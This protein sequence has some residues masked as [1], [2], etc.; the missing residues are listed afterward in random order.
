[1]SDISGN[2]WDNGKRVYGA[3]QGPLNGPLNKYLNTLTQGLFT[4][5]F[6]CFVMVSVKRFADNRIKHK[7]CII[8]SNAARSRS[9]RAQVVLSAYVLQQCV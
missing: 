3:A 6:N 2:G 7:L 8:L 4:A 5:F 9:R 1:M